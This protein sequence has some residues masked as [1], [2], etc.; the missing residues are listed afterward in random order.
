M[1][2][3]PQQRIENVAQALEQAREQRIAAEGQGPGAATSCRRANCGR[4]YWHPMGTTGNLHATDD[5][6]EMNALGPANRRKR[7]AID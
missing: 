3:P 2:R 7:A 1:A 6:V 5:E 4:P